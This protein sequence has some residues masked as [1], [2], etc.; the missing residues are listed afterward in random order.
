MICLKEFDNEFYE[1]LKD[2]EKIL[3]DKKGTYHTIFFEGEKVGI[4]GFIP[5]LKNKN[6]GFIQIIIAPKFMGKGIARNAENLF[7]A[8]YH[9]KKLYA[10]IDKTNGPSIKFHEKIGFKKLSNEEQSILKEKGFLKKDKI[11][12]SRTF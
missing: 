10:T 8:K 5:S 9:L 2:K 6:E 12:M 1:S 4:V 11:R 7:V 3:V